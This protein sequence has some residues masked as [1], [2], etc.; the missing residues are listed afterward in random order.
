MRLFF[1]IYAPPAAINAVQQLLPWLK[2]I[3]AKL[4]ELHNLHFSLVFLGDVPEAKLPCLY[5]VGEKARL[6]TKP[7]YI[8]LTNLELIPSAEN[9]RVLAIHAKADHNYKKLQTELLTRLNKLKLDDLSSKPAHFTL[10]RLKSMVSL[11]NTQF[12]PIT[13]KLDE[14][15]LIQSKLT[16]SGP[17]YKPLKTFKIGCSESVGKYRVNVSICLINN[18]NEVFLIKSGLFPGEHWQLPQGGAE[19]GETIEQ[20]ARRE[21]KEETNIDNFEIIKVG[22]QSSKYR[23]P[24]VDETAEIIGQEQHPIY[25]K[26]LGKNTDIRL[27]YREAVEYKWVNHINLDN[28]VYPSRKKFSQMVKEELIK[29]IK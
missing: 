20:A 27:N 25:L 26:F 16:S 15:S 18:K 1:G 12:N 21:L 7:L 19:Q 14:F 9:S 29:I 28:E 11:E 23:F 5:E 2:S 22:E 4:V 17:I 10:A 13:F 6:K 24:R 3:P 8:S